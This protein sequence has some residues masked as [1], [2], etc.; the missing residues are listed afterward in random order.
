MVALSRTQRGWRFGC[1]DPPCFL[2]TTPQIHYHHHTQ[3]KQRRERHVGGRATAGGDDRRTGLRGEPDRVQHP[4]GG[5]LPGV[6]TGAG[7]CVCAPSFYTYIYLHVDMWV[8]VCTRQG[9][10]SHITYEATSEAHISCAAGHITI[11]QIREFRAVLKAH[12]RLST[13]R[14]R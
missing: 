11:K 8:Y 12:G 6:A 4:R 14:E 13:L 1:Q 7:A 10:M 2:F 3:K 5:R 9:Y